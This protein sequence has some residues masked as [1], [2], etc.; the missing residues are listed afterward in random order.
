[1]VVLFAKYAFYEKLLLFFATFS[2]FVVC[3][4]LF[5]TVPCGRHLMM[6]T[7]THIVHRVYNRV[8][9]MSE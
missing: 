3:F 4:D 7:H 1:M 5:V 2:C 6:C 9:R 8:Q